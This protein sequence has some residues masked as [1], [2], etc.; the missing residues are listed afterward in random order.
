MKSL[1]IYKESDILFII[2]KIIKLL[3]TKKRN[4]MRTIKYLLTS[5]LIISLVFFSCNEDEEPPIEEQQELA[6]E[7][8]RF[9]GVSTLVEINGISHLAV[10]SSPE[11]AM[12]YG[13]DKKSA[14]EMFAPGLNPCTEE[15]SIYGTV[16]CDGDDDCD[17]NS[18]ELHRWN[19]STK[20]WVSHGS[21]SALAFGNTWKCICQ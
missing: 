8:V 5:V 18:C 14:L 2:R 13:F 11:E 10:M 20:S 12:S 3:S 4:I 19:S 16:S 6:F 15:F 21:S 17:P 9:T 1:R 7:K